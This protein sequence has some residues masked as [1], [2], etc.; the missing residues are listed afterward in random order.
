M[1]LYKRLR[2]PRKFGKKSLEGAE[3]YK[4]DHEEGDFDKI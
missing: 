3:F 4:N 1:K 2:I